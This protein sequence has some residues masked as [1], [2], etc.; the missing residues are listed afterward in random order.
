MP[1]WILDAAKLFGP[2]G[3][4]GAILVFAV[5]RLYFRYDEIQEKRIADSLAWQAAVRDNTEILRSFVDSQKAAALSISAMADAQRATTTQLQMTT[6]EV[7]K[8]GVKLRVVE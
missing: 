1:D 8:I 3:V 7:A 5:V 2:P 6:L 4:I